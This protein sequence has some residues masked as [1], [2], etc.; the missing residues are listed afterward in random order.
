MGGGDTASQGGRTQQ[1]LLHDTNKLIGVKD[2]MDVLVKCWAPP[3]SRTALKV[4]V[5]DL[6]LFGA[7]D[8]LFSFQCLV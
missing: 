4:I 2:M 7:Y 8:Q 1:T 3:A 6:K 5:T